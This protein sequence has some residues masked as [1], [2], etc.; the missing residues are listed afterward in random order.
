M[1]KIT[2]QKLAEIKGN[3]SKPKIYNGNFPLNDISDREFEVLCYLLF[4]ERIKYDDIEL[5][6]KFDKIDLMSGIGEKG[7]DATLY[8]NDQIVGL[9]QCKKHKTR[10][11]KPMVIKEILKFVLHSLKTP[12]LLPNKQKFTYYIIASS[13]FANTTIEL[14]SNFNKKILK[15]DIKKICEDLIKENKGL[16]D[17][18][19]DDKL[20]DI[21]NILK[22]IK[23][24]KGNP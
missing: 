16:I 12:V 10:L 9:I 17:L 23:I 20:Q 15:E 14:L 19:I 1:E 24:Q 6:G 5:S 2:E 22:S 7:F 4:K 11:H 21:T 8:S 3:A 18:N 13:G